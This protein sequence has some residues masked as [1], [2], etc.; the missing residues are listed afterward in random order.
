MS[1]KMEKLYAA[2]RDPD[3]TNF[4]M[5]EGMVGDRRAHF[6]LAVDEDGDAIPVALLLDKKMAAHLQAL[7]ERATDDGPGDEDE[8]DE[9]YEDDEAP[10]G[11]AYR[12]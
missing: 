10:R 8:D 1:N 5:G 12:P 2:I 4:E 6:I 3:F 7:V 9:E 11:K